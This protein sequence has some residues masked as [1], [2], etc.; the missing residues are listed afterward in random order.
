MMIKKCNQM[1]R[2]KTHVCRTRKNL[3]QEEIKYNN[4]IKRYKKNIK[5]DVSKENNTVHNQYLA[6]ISDYTHRILIT[7]GS[8][9]GKKNH[10]SI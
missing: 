1:T 7:G 3:K 8:G 2:Y 6:Q 5:F 10:Y 4:I 9:F